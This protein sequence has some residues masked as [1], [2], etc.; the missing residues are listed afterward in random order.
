[1]T[2]LLVWVVDVLQV[3]SLA[4][5][6]FALFYALQ[7]AVATSIA[8]SENE[9]HSK[10]EPAKAAGFGLLTLLSIVITICGISSE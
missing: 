6:A 7:C 2:I 5:R 4:S 3:I 9:N 1:M 10:R 8:W